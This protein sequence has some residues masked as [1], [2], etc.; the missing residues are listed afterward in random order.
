[1]SQHIVFI[2][3]S[4]AGIETMHLA[5][6][7]GLRVSF[8]RAGYRHYIMTE[9]NIRILSKL[10][11]I[12]DISA[13]TVENEVLCALEHIALVA[14]ID[15]VI[16]ELEPCVDVV[17]RVCAQ[18][19]ILFTSSSAVSA[20]RD[21]LRARE[22]IQ[23]AGLR[24]PQFRQ[25][26]APREARAAAEAMG[27][28]V[29]I[30]PQTGY[31][32]LLAAIAPTPRDAECAAQ[33]LLLGIDALPVHLQSQFRKGILVEEYLVGPLVS[34]EMGVLDDKFYRFMLSDHPRARQ[35]E[36]I[37][38]GASM[39]ANLSP[40]KMNACFL[41]AEA[42]ARE[43]GFD[44]GIF[45]AEMI[46]TK[47]GPVLI[48]MNPRLMGGVMPSVYRHLTGESIQERLIDIHLGLP[49]RVKPPKYSGCVSARN[50]MPHHDAIL[51]DRVDM[52]WLKDCG[53]ELIEFNPH[54]LDSG[55]AVRRAE[56]LGWY[57]VRAKSFAEA[58]TVAD[59][60]LH[61]VE[62]SIGV[63]LIH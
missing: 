43:L 55:L 45:H 20:A 61:R 37:E 31:F 60:I 18:L 47:E 1:M 21:K 38:M 12:I 49:I 52:S 29:V 30:K 58:N 3:S 22:I 32:S 7:R 40:D 62:R 59:T 46:L 50:I 33:K 16:T 9:R 42:V 56:I 23:H 10:D 5:K 14:P 25:V 4:R 48:E 8:I 24:C 39:P 6:K 11:N 15:A 26:T 28:P 53:S 34:A 44:L 54:R 19:G 57:H 13:S 51:A 63:P 2:D 17:A 41:Y 36:C 27:T 35:D